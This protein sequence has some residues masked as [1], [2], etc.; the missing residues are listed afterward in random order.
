MFKGSSIG[1]KMKKRKLYVF[2]Y[3]GGSS[4]AFR[5]ISQKMQGEIDIEL[6][7]Y[8][9]HGMRFDE[10]LIDDIDQLSEKMVDYI[11]ED[12]G[13]NNITETIFLGHSMGAK[14]AYETAYKLEDRINIS[15]LILCGSEPT[16]VEND[17]YD[18]LSREKAFERVYNMGFI[19][20]EVKEEKE[21]Y[22]V[23]SEIIYS[24]MR[25]LAS[26][27]KRDNNYSVNIPIHVLAGKDDEDCRYDDMFKWKEKTTKECDITYLGGSHFFL[28]ENQ[29][30][31]CGQ[32]H[33]LLK[34]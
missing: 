10:T 27:G 23:F 28:F 3:A 33:A 13:K 16:H 24:D 11:L 14:V 2:P 25:I 20:A 5:E 21:L 22:D 4:Y 30:E 19:P 15:Q 31:F 8:P 12:Q 26:F 1:V 7:D 18:D 9:G 6:L 17:K 29:D 34:K 32:I